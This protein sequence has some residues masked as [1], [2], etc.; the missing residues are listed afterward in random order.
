MTWSS[1][2]APQS[3]ALCNPAF[4]SFH[5]RCDGSNNTITL[6]WWRHK[7]MAAVHPSLPRPMLKLSSGQDSAAP[8]SCMSPANRKRASPSP[9]ALRNCLS[10]ATHHALADLR[11]AALFG[12]AACESPPWLSKKARASC[13][14]S[15]SPAKKAARP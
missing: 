1:T 8:R 12:G 6:V 13:C 2:A 4:E 14:H 5:A 9:H 10:T 7:Y 11:M 15:S 3:F